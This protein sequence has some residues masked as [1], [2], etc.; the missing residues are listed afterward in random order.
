MIVPRRLIGATISHGKIYVFGGVGDNTSDSRI[1]VQTTETASESSTALNEIASDDDPER[2]SNKRGREPFW[3]VSDT[4]RPSDP[5]DNS[6]TV[7]G[8][9]MPADP[10]HVKDSTERTSRDTNKPVIRLDKD[11]SGWFSNILEVY[12]I[13]RDVWMVCKS[14]L[15]FS[16]ATSVVTVSI[17]GVD[18]IFVFIHGKGCYRYDPESDSYESRGPLPL[19]DWYNFVATSWNEYVFLHG[20]KMSL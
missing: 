3:A 2:R 5:H 17:D 8:L 14:R 19:K 6:T 1:P 16:D 12:D 11:D 7:E 13:E 20:G 15:P 4:K 18:H 10:S 9:A